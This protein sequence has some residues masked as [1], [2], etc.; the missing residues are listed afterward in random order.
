MPACAYACARASEGG[1][2]KSKQVWNPETLRFEEVVEDDA[3][4]EGRWFKIHA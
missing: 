4:N 3:E 2:E 1:A